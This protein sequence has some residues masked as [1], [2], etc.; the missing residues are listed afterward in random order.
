MNPHT[1]NEHYHM[2]YFDSPV[3]TGFS[4]VNNAG[5]ATNEDDVVTDLY[6]A[7]TTFFGELYPQF[8]KNAL[9][10]FGES[11]AG[12][13]IPS[14]A[15]YISNQAITAGKDTVQI[16]LKGVGIGDGWVDPVPQTLGIYS[17]FCYD[18]GLIDDIQRANIEVMEREVVAAVDQGRWADA[19]N[20][21]NN[22]TLQIMEGAGM[23]NP[24]DIRKYGFASFAPF[25]V[26]TK[27]VTQPSVMAKLRV[28]PEA[29]FTMINGTVAQALFEDNM[30][31]VVPSVISIL[32]AGLPVLI[33]NGNFD[34]TVPI[35]GTEAWLDQMQWQGSSGWRAATRSVWTHSSQTAGYMKQY[36]NLMFVTVVQAGHMAAM[37][38][39]ARV[40][41]MVTRFIEGKPFH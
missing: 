22:I 12:K 29:N 23:V 30:K 33:F 18:T 9:Y 41:D 28:A 17:S 27:F 31:T 20:L 8:A 6:N 16:N 5:L 26:T 11:Y 32:G 15:D 38:Q 37:D 39:P 1:W 14:L 3:G 13:Y 36:A 7:L 19:T 40:K 34:F 24:S 25:D 10:I 4:Y 2:L 21:W 35:I